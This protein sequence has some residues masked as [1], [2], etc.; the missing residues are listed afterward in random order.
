[1]SKY[2]TPLL[3]SFQ[4]QLLSTMIVYQIINFK[5]YDWCPSQMYRK[6]L[7]IYYLWYQLYIFIFF[8]NWKKKNYCHSFT[9]YLTWGKYILE[10]YCKILFLFSAMRRRIHFL[11]DLYLK[12][13]FLYQLTMSNLWRSDKCILNLNN[14]EKSNKSNKRRS[15]SII[16]RASAL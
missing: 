2:T 16:V 15:Q 11:L 10:E 8:K 4:Q 13:L 9:I 3:P 5:K 7:L 1:M 6:S 12:K 14:V